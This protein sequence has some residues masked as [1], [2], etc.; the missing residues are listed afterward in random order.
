MG[1]L[2]QTLSPLP[3]TEIWASQNIA[4]RSP[5]SEMFRLRT[6]QAVETNRQLCVKTWKVRMVEARPSACNKSEHVVFILGLGG[7]LSDLT[8]DDIHG[9]V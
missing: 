1:S 4:R 3:L 2:L 9:S 5:C 7:M 8:F 6:L